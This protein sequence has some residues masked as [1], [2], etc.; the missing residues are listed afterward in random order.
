MSRGITKEWMMKQIDCS[1]KWAAKDRNYYP[2]QEH[3]TQQ[4]I[5]EFVPC[6]CDI[7][8]TCRQFGCT[9]HL[10]LKSGID[11]VDF[12]DGF[13]RMFVDWHQH[14]PMIDALTGKGFSGLISRTKNAV[15]I[16]E[17]LKDSWPVVSAVASDH[18]KTLF[19]G[20][21]IPESFVDQWS[22]SFKKASIY[23]AK[24]YCI[25]FPDIC[26]PYDIKSRQKLISHLNLSDTNYIGVLSKLR[27]VF[28]DCMSS[29]DLTLPALRQLD[30]PHERLPFDSK[31]IR[32]PR[33]GVDYSFGYTSAER[34]ISIVLDKCFY[35]PKYPS[36]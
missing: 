32:L 8:C 23:M 11:F 35:Q 6:T 14:Q 4:E 2:I 28:L 1:N 29:S 21:W 5:W 15:H 27:E 16:L 24:Q 17:E 13:L 9:H 34:P 20:D 10:K 18:N 30:A 7:N 26:V 36:L 19:C 31:K 25:L 12:R 33:S 3:V 22:F